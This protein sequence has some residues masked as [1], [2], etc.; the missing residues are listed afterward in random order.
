MSP[1]LADALREAVM[2]GKQ[3]ELV[4]SRELISGLAA[5][6]YSTMRES[7]KGRAN[8]GIYVSPLPIRFGMT[9]TDGYLS[10]GLYR[11]GKDIYNA[12]LDLISTD[13]AAVAWGERLFQYYKADS[14]ALWAPPE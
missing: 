12:A 8:F 7:L 1:L 4:I 3:V 5:E 14:R 11:R 10:L 9:V 6:P 13:A 2:D